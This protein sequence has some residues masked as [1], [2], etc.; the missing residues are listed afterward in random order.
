M[1]TGL[2]PESCHASTPPG[3]A[4]PDANTATAK[5]RGSQRINGKRGDCTVGSNLIGKLVDLGR[6]LSIRRDERIICDGC[7]CERR[8][9]RCPQQTRDPDLV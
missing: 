3:E 2:A 5:T 7:V 1:A 9:Q 6:R 8:E 4:N